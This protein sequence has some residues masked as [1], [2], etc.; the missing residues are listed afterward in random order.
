[1]RA[2]GK[3]EDKAWLVLHLGEYRVAYLE[4]EDDDEA[5]EPPLIWWDH[6]HDSEICEEGQEEAAAQIDL[7][8]HRHNAS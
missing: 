5:A 4:R 1:M 8:L 2:I 3:Q 7:P 6:N